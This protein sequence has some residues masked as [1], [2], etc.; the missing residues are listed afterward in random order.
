MAR[1]P[2]PARPH[3]QRGQLV[4]RLKNLQ[5][6]TVVPRRSPRWQGHSPC[7]AGNAEGQAC[8]R[9]PWACSWRSHLCLGQLGPLSRLCSASTGHSAQGSG[10]QWSPP[11]KEAVLVLGTHWV[12]GGS[13]SPG[14]LAGTSWA[15]AEEP[16]GCQGPAH[17]TLHMLFLLPGIY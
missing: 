13:C 8:P 1:S 6:L 4:R 2:G 14:R 16:G 3:G 15:Q 10:G 7:T 17:V 5:R 12:P 9:W 11:C